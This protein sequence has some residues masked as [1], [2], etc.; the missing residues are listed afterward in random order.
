MCLIPFVS[1]DTIADLR[2][3]TEK[4]LQA[5]RFEFPKATV[6]PKMHYLNDKANAE[7]WA[8]EAPVVHVN[9]GK[10]AFFKN[11]KWKC[12]KNLPLSTANYVDKLLYQMQPRK[13][14]F[15]P[16]LENCRFF[17]KFIVLSR[18]I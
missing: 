18:R 16:K 11:K 15:N 5:F 14:L 3:L 6:P 2:N 1:L 13:T 17:R 8:I 4:H 12:F 10:H 7:F 9:R